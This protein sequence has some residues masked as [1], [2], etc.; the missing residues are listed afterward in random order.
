MNVMESNE[1]IAPSPD[2]EMTGAKALAASTLR[3]IHASI[4][5]VLDRTALFHFNS[6]ES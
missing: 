2:R 4:S 6:L 1:S 3:K 5:P